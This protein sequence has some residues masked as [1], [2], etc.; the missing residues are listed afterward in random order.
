MKRPAPLGRV[1]SLKHQDKTCLGPCE[2]EDLWTGSAQDC[3]QHISLKKTKNKT[4]EVIL[5]SS[6][7]I[8]FF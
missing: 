6:P 5:I 7:W 3:G 4:Q 1:G 8:H 2:N